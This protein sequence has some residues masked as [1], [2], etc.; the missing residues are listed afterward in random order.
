[1]MTGAEGYSGRS[2]WPFSYLWGGNFGYTKIFRTKTSSVIELG[3]QFI[4]RLK[5]ER[6]RFQK[7]RFNHGC[8]EA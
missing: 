8:F 4:V 1:M 5:D 7:G 2:R 6:I 3:Q